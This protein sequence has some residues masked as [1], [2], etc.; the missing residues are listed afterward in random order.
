MKPRITLGRLACPTTF[1]AAWG[2]RLNRFS[3]RWTN[4]GTGIG[5]EQGSKHG[6]CLGQTPAKTFAN[7]SRFGDTPP[8][9][10]AIAGPMPPAVEILREGDPRRPE[11]F[12]GGFLQ[13]EYGQ[14]RARTVERFLVESIFCTGGLRKGTSFFA[15]LQDLPKTRPPDPRNILGACDAG[16]FHAD[17]GRRRI[18]GLS[19]DSPSRRR[20][21]ERRN[22]RRATEA[23]LTGPTLG[24]GDTIQAAREAFA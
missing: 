5:G 24:H 9:D 21:P 10:L 16:A 14:R 19:T 13:F 7:G 17:D 4:C 8:T 2:L 20:W 22:E 11:R 12:C 6:H 15:R 1:C 18:G 23:A 3:R